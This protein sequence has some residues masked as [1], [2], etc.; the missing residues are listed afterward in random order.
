MTSHQPRSQIIFPEAGLPSVARRSLLAKA[1]GR[2]P[3]GRG[4]PGSKIKLNRVSLDV[5]HQ[6][7]ARSSAPSQHGSPDN[8]IDR[9]FGDFMKDFCN[10]IG[11]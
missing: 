8:R 6:Y 5:L 7:R 9:L 11:R 10:D 3:P 4:R 1:A 2:W